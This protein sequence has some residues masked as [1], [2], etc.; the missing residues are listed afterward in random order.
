MCLACKEMDFSKLDE[1]IALS[2]K[3]EDSLIGILHKTQ[4]LYGYV[5]QEAQAHIADALTIPVSR[6]YGVVTFY[7]YFLEKPR[8]KYQIS[9]CLGTACY[10]KGAQDV[11]STLEE[12]L[13]IKYGETTSDLM[14]SIA[15]TRCLGDCSNAPVMMINDELYGNV[16]PAE[17]P[18]I[19]DKYRE[20]VR[21]D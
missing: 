8:G 6:V 12:E 2:D 1:I 17:I 21:N 11:L 10:V 5:P 3:R 16:I 19:I 13:G 15:Q 9:V 4:E 18:A 7:S 14:F 20:E